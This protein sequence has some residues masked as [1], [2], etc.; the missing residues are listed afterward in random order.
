MNYL[1]PNRLTHH[2]K[3]AVLPVLFS[4]ILKMTHKRRPESRFGFKYPGN[5]LP[6]RPVIRTSK[7]MN[8]SKVLYGLV[9]F[10][11]KF[12]PFLLSQLIVSI[13]NRNHEITLI[14]SIHLIPSHTRKNTA[15]AQ[16][17]Q[18]LGESLA[19][20]RTPDSNTSN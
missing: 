16:P 11:N 20:I 4:D 15:S 10:L 12:I 5:I 14:H 19:S 2:K 7:E 1:Y 13:S 9:N 17:A 8:L 3:S 18:T 6:R